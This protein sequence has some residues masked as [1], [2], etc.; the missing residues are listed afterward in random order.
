M[1]S[2]SFVVF[3]EDEEVGEALR[4]LLEKTGKA[5]VADVVHERLNL[6]KTLERERPTRLLV[7]L[8]YAPHEV[9]D[10]LAEQDLPHGG[11]VVCGSKEDSEI[12][13]RALKQGAREFLTPSPTATEVTELV[14]KFSREAAA[15]PSQPDEGL[16]IAVMGA[17]GGVGGTLVTCQLAAHLQK[18][19]RRTAALD[20]NFP[21]GD[22][23]LHFDLTPTYTLADIVD[24]SD[25]I[26]GTLVADL[27]DK[28][29]KSGVEVLAAPSRV[30][31]AER[32]DESHVDAVLQQLRTRFDRIVVDVSRSWGPTSVRALEQA[33]LIIL[34]ALQDVPSLNHARAHRDLLV[35]LGTKP[36]MIRT[37]INRNAKDAAVSDE[38]LARFLGA[39]PDFYI[40]NDYRTSILSVN[41]GRP[42]SDVAPG[43]AI[44]DAF[45]TLASRS[46]EWL[47]LPAAPE[48]TQKRSRWNKGLFRNIRAKKK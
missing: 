37:V 22:V 1:S 39:T 18:M 48:E 7:D 32:V 24:A 11:F 30:E 13:L 41:E 44:D 28:H 23:A 47:G 35:R 6:A 17:K 5:R 33:D 42:I 43:S 31:D 20:L 36:R 29:T 25:E 15:V 12:I 16:V 9:L 21:L 10:L 45:Q 2:I 46:S 40:P 27:L 8:G 4:E 38:D 34:V 14:E 3:A 26:D 19:G